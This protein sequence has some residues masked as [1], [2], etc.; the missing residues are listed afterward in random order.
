MRKVVC[1]FSNTR[2]DKRIVQALHLG[3][4]RHGLDVVSVPKSKAILDN[5]TP[6]DLHVFVGVRSSSLHVLKVAGWQQRPYVMLDKGYFDRNHTHRMSVGSPQPNYIHLMDYDDKR[7]RKLGFRGIGA[8]H[9][10]GLRRK[11]VYVASTQK[12][13]TFHGLGDMNQYNEWAVSKLQATV[14]NTGLVVAHRPRGAPGAAPFSHLLS[15]AHCVVVHGSNA[16]V[17]ALAAGVPVVSLG[18]PNCNPIHDIVNQDFADVLVPTVP[19]ERV[20]VR[21][22]AQLA[23]CQFNIDEIRDGTAWEHTKRWM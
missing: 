9:K 21:R 6:G 16:G 14:A 12:Y 22:L 5:P 23:W 19:D 18:N 3:F 10:Q 13:Y 11:V 15:T 17:Q 4:E 20:A 7:L 8:Q 1:Y 2:R